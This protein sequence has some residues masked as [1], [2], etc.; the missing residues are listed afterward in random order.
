MPARRHAAGHS[1]RRSPKGMPLFQT[2]ASVRA[3]KTAASDKDLD[4]G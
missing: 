3:G 1:N 4:I 2:A